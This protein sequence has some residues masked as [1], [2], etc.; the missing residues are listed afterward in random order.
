MVLLSLQLPKTSSTRGAVF[1][2]GQSTVTFSAMITCARRALWKP[3]C[4][5]TQDDPQEFSTL[6]RALQET[7]LCALAP[8]A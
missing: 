5:H 3:W 1:W 8:A 2:R 4:F 7:L 6:S